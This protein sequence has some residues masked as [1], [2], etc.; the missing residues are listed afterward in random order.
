M[1]L[2]VLAWAR[3]TWHT[4]FAA[5]ALMA[6]ESRHRRRAFLCVSS[7]SGDGGWL[8]VH[9]NVSAVTDDTYSR[10]SHQLPCSY[11]VAENRLM[12]DV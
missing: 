10:R 2:A 9:I 3:L 8:F 5:R 12:V 4:L 1:Q 6:Q 7:V 11:G